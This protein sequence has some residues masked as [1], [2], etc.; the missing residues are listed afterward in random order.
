MDLVQVGLSSRIGIGHDSDAETSKRHALGHA[1]KEKCFENSS[2]YQV[3][4]GGQKALT[5]RP[6]QMPQNPK[7]RTLP[8]GLCTVRIKDDEDEYGPC[9]TERTMVHPGRFSLF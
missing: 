9:I 2:D 5:A 1:N 6:R 7:G 3:L 4:A 8:V